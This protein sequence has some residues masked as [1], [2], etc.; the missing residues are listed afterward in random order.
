MAKE[1]EYPR[2]TDFCKGCGGHHGPDPPEVFVDFEWRNELRRFHV[3]FHCLCCGIEICASQ[4]AWGRCCGH[5][6]TGAC[7]LGRVEPEHFDPR[8]LQIIY[9]EGHGQKDLFYEGELIEVP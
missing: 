5:C 7:Q 3:P 6:D 4:F 1:D 2:M 8:K 9:E